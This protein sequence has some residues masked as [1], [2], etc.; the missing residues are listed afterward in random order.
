MREQLLGAV[1]RRAA[2]AGSRVDLG[3]LDQPI[4]WFRPSASA[5]P[6]QPAS[7]AQGLVLRIGPVAGSGGV[8]T[9]LVPSG[10][11]LTASLPLT[12]WALAVDGGERQRDQR[13]E[14][15]NGFHAALLEVR[16]LRS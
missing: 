6:W 5:P 11:T 16:N 7:A 14:M 15:T 8:S 12:N 1:G 2:G 3:A 13:E 4:R 10:I 9:F